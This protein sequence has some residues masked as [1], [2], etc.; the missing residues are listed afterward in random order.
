M[1]AWRRDR[2]GRAFATLAVATLWIG[3]FG[4]SPD[5]RFY[6]LN[7]VGSA[8]GD[9]GTAELAI[10]VGP[11]TFPRYLDRP[12][13]VT[14]IETSELA[15]DELHRWAGGFT[16]NVQSALAENLAARLGSARVLANPNAAPFPLDYRVGVDIQRLEAGPGA[17]LALRARWIVRDEADRERHW[18]GESSI[19]VPLPSGDAAGSVAAHEMALAQLADAIAARVREVEAGRAAP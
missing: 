15:Y 18:R 19:E 1:S 9:G 17:T 16:A 10:G 2:R 12:Q 5:V 3:C 4:R 13:L 8:S 6:T 14:R 11:V 7:A